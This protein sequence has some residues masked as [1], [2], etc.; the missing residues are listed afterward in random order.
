MTRS[1]TGQ[2]KQGVLAP[3]W[4]IAV[5]HLVQMGPLLANEKLQFRKVRMED[6]LARRGS[7]FD[8]RSSNG[9]HDEMTSD[10]PLERKSISVNLSRFQCELRQKPS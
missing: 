1:S 2:S 9:L 6:N 3:A 8:R 5:L 4:L 10:D 7:A